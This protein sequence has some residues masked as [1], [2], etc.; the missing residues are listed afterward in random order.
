MAA[1]LT[2][3]A[4]EQS[5]I[6]TPDFL[7]N[8]TPA[9]IARCHGAGNTGVPVGAIIDSEWPRSCTVFAKTEQSCAL[10]RRT[11]DR[12]DAALPNQCTVFG[13]R[14]ATQAGRTPT[15]HARTSIN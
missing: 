12:E 14:S 13:R 4:V 3:T 11:H 6:R 9:E 8:R 7:E 2:A 5:E 10:Q 15:R 1:G